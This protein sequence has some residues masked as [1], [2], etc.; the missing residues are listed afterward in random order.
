MTEAIANNFQT[1]LSGN[2]NNSTTTIPLTSVTGAPSGGNWRLLVGSEIMLVT[3][4]ASLNATVTRGVEGT[5]AASHNSGD[6]ATAVLTAASL[7]QVIADHAPTPS[8][9][10]AKFGGTGSITGV[11]LDDT[12]TAGNTLLLAATG[13]NS[14]F[15]SGMT[16]TN[17]TWTAIKQF[18][19]G[20]GIKVELW[21]GHVNASA[22]KAI[23]FTNPNSFESV[24]VMEITA[25]V[26]STPVA[27]STQSGEQNG[28]TIE[29]AATTAGHLVAAMSAVDNTTSGN[30]SQVSM[31][32][33]FVGINSERVS[34]IAGYSSGGRTYAGAHGSPTAGGVILAE[35]T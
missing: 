20:G 33:P 21:A 18:T 12:P 27:G 6:L 23:T 30:W 28:D 9:L 35:I 7:V 5:S 11:T 13:S 29:I 34:V 25:S 32:V 4:V 24:M 15:L 1:T 17:V 14:G 26:S 10:Q 3:S 16:Q 2:V 8:V 22:G 31:S 19:N